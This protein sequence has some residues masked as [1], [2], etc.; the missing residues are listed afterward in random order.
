MVE[1][2]GIE[3]ANGEV[4]K[5]ITEEGYTYLGVMELD[6]VMEGGDEEKGYE[7]VL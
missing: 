7:R 6:Q 5:R 4:I 1:C 2:H 3:L